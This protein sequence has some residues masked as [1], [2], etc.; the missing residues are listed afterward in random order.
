MYACLSVPK[1]RELE[2]WWVER[3][4]CSQETAP[5]P[6]CIQENF[7]WGLILLIY[8]L[9]FLELGVMGSNPDLASS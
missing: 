4:K 7:K 2:H 9:S 5:E 1:R 8:L 6:V 3:G